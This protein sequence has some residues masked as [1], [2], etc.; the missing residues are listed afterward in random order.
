MTRVGSRRMRDGFWVDRAG[1]AIWAGSGGGFG[2]RVMVW[3]GFRGGF[4]ARVRV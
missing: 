2:A 4:G 3:A 1:V